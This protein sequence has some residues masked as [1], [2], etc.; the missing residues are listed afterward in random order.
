M[1]T[2]FISY[3]HA[4]ID[5]AVRIKKQLERI[6]FKIWQDKENLRGGLDWKLQIFDAL[7]D[8]D[9]VLLILSEASVSSRFVRMEWK[10]ALKRN[11]KILP[12]LLET[13]IIP[14]ELINIQYIDFSNLSNYSDSF[15]SL[16]RDLSDNV[17]PENLASRFQVK[18]K[19]GDSSIQIGQAQNVTIKKTKS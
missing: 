5:F 16:V 3:A 18:Q 14:K 10:T 2:L 6:G 15:S 12:V 7:M 17:R 4:N 8:V 1:N 19:S 9:I 11:K 13:C